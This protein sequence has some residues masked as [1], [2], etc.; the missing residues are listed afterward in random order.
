MKYQIV[1]KR[2]REDNLEVLKIPTIN[3]LV[4]AMRY[5]DKEL[6]L[7]KMEFPEIQMFIKPVGEINAGKHDR[8]VKYEND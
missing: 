2:T 3:G 8:K 1:E 7:K 6:P 5:V 4:K